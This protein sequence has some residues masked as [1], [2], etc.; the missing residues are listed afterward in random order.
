MVGIKAYK[1]YWKNMVMRVAALKLAVMVANE[2]QLKSVVSNIGSYPILVSTVPSA[3]ANSKD[4]DNTGDNNLGIIFI[5]KKVSSNDRSEEAYEDNMQLMQ[6]AMQ[7]VRDNMEADKTDCDAT[8]HQIMKDL[9]VKSFNQDPEF[10]YL[11][12]DGWS[13]SFKFGS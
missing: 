1:E 13:L 9:D 5:L 6:D 10:N 7:E 12:H 8:G 4:E 2:A 3:S 11:G